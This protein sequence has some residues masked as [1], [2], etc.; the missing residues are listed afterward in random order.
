MDEGLSKAVLKV[1]VELYRAG[2][3]YKDLRLVNWDPT[4]GTAVSDKDPRTGAQTQTNEAD[5]KNSATGSGSS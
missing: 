4:L 3:I 5:E 2:L 1:F